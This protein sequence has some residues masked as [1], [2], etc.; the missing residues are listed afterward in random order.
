MHRRLDTSESSTQ[1][2]HDEL[3]ARLHDLIPGGAHTYAKGDD[4]Y[5]SNAPAVLVRGSGCRAWDDAGREFLEYGIGLRS[6]VLGHG[7]PAVVE[8]VCRQVQ[9]GTNFNRPTLLELEAAEALLEFVGQG[10]MVKFAKNGSDVTTA[11]VKLARGYT[12]RDLVA[13]CADQ[14]FFSTD[15]WFIGTT[16]MAEGIPESTRAMTVKFRYNNLA[17]VHE[18]FARNAGQIS[19]VVMEAATATLPADGYLHGVQEACKQNGALFVLDETITGF[20]WPGGTAQRHYGLTP[21]LST[22]G[23]GLGN[24]FAISALVG[25]REVM[26]LGGLRHDRKRLFLLSTTHGAETHSLAAA[27][28]TMQVYRDEQ[29]IQ[30]FHRLGSQLKTELNVVAQRLGIAKNFEVLGQPSNLVFATRD[31]AGQPSQAFRTLFMQECVRRG[32]LAPSLVLSFAHGAAELEQTVEIVSAALEIYQK[33]LEN[34]V[35]KYV[36]GSFVK[37]VFRNYN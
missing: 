3:R 13:I 37:P 16:A 31:A 21:D 23:K 12:G 14:P 36:V 28:A 5:P 32:M 4:Q 27:L 6:V 8:A 2:S 30:H 33:A 9:L 1:V 29:V 34:G 20:R 18:M 22:F 7:H 19:C 15:D 10:D 26:E 17:S 24:G 25:R 35:E 11:A